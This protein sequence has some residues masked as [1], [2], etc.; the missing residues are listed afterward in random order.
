MLSFEYNQTS[1]VFVDVNVGVQNHNF[2]FPLTLNK[3]TI[4]IVMQKIKFMQEFTSAIN[5]ENLH[6]SL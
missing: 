6:S 1:S 2:K 3:Y 5:V 4:M